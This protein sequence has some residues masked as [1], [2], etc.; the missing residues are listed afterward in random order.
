MVNNDSSQLSYPYE[1]FLALRSQQQ[2]NLFSRNSD[3]LDLHNKL[4]GP[5]DSKQ[6]H[7]I[8]SKQ[9]NF[10]LA[11]DNLMTITSNNHRNQSSSP[12]T[13]SL[14]NN[15]NRLQS[16]LPINNSSVILPNLQPDGLVLVKTS[17]GQ[18][19]YC[20][21]N[22]YNNNN[23]NNNAIP[24]KI[25][26][27]TTTLNNNIDSSI[28]SS[29][30]SSISSLSS[31]P[32]F[33][34]TL[35]VP[36]SLGSSMTSTTPSAS[37]SVAMAAAHVAS[38]AT[39]EQQCTS[40]TSV[41]WPTNSLLSSSPSSSHHASVL[42]A[43]SNINTF[44]ST[45]APKQNPVLIEQ[46][47]VNHAH[48]NNNNNYSDLIANALASTNKQLT[49]DGTMNF[50]REISYSSMNPSRDSDD[51]I[52]DSPKYSRKMIVEVSSFTIYFVSHKKFLECRKK[53]ITVKCKCFYYGY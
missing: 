20:P 14:V 26:N 29:N 40:I 52:S 11:L 21:S 41:L 24:Q 39:Y 22:H 16:T 48:R 17:V 42:S 5:V 51:S 19:L 10:P 30:C 28:S 32:S 2:S 46:L 49:D 23:D 7:E 15:G 12:S 18:L 53:Y 33:T 9:L 1:A 34:S 13:S 47:N 25:H 36:N 37:A 45:V 6:Q 8:D 38:V 43:K 4:L 50:L 3:T 35:S 44:P 31:V 27:S